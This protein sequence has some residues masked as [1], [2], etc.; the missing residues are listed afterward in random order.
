MTIVKDTWDQLK[1][2]KIIFEQSR[3][4]TTRIVIRPKYDLD[5][6]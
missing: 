4:I 6:F 1:T 5:K 2:N 3:K